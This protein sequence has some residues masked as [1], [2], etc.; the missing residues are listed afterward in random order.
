MPSS[1]ASLAARLREDS[2]H[3]KSLWDRAFDELDAHDRQRLA[4]VQP[5]R[6]TVLED[7]LESV[8]QKKQTCLEKRWAIRKAN[9]DR[10]ILRDLCEKV[11]CWIDKFKAVGDA[12]TQYDPGHA[13]LPWAAVRFVL[14]L[15]E[16]ASINEVLVQEKGIL[17]ANPATEILLY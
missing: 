11:V 16:Q 3:A 8:E 9:G 15:C 7:V 14:Q 4:A 2:A 6:L 13:A 10:V 17:E 12:A 1:Q 5:D